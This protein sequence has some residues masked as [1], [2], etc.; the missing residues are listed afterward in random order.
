MSHVDRYRATSTQ[1]LHHTDSNQC[2]FAFVLIYITICLYQYLLWL[3]DFMQL[4]WCLQHLRG[5]WDPAGSHLTLHSGRI[6][7]VINVLCSITRSKSIMD[8][9]GFYRFW[10]DLEEEVFLQHHQYVQAQFVTSEEMCH[11][12]KLHFKYTLGRLLSEGGWL[13][14]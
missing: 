14:A 13:M 6:L 9:W 5:L 3:C 8:L 11:L 1:W 12:D 2:I 7:S 4:C 10:L